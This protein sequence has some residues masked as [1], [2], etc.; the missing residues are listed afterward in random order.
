[1]NLKLCRT[2]RPCSWHFRHRQNRSACSCVFGATFQCNFL[3]LCFNKVDH[4]MAENWYNSVFYKFIYVN[5]Y[6]GFCNRIVSVFCHFMVY[7]VKTKKQKITLESC[8]KNTTTG[9]AILSV[10]EMSW[11]RPVC[12]ADFYMTS[13]A[14][15]FP[16]LT[17][18]EQTNI[19][20][21]TCISFQPVYGLV[22]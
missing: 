12:A 9:T 22:C 3:F 20:Q 17:G 1:M 6:W 8:T 19:K 14:N 4:K 13:Q 10:S 2:Y 18:K 11:T 7:F 15:T 21:Q 5:T 16:L